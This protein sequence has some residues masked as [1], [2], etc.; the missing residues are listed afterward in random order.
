MIVN[1]ESIFILT[2]FFH[3]ISL[4]NPFFSLLSF[5]KHS[6]NFFALF[7]SKHFWGIIGH[8]AQ[9]CIVLIFAAPCTSRSA[10]FVALLNAAFADSMQK[11]NEEALKKLQE[12]IR[13]KEGFDTGL[14]LHFLSILKE[15]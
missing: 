12:A 2:M 3:V 8:L 10:E 6:D 7:F 14:F 13:M 5:R 15:N 11:R 1:D 4:V 9:R